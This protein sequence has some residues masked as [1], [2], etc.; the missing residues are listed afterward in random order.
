MNTYWRYKWCGLN[1]KH[2]HAVNALAHVCRE[3][4]N[5][6]H[7]SIYTAVIPPVY[8]KSYRDLSTRKSRRKFTKSDTTAAVALAVTSNREVLTTIWLL[9]R[10]K[11]GNGVINVESILS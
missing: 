10:M 1:K 4:R 7:V 3:I 2:F 8:L 9:K 11:L 5:K 6:Q